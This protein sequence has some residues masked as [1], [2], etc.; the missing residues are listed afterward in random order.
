MFS[1]INMQIACIII[2][3]SVQPREC[4]NNFIMNNPKINAWQ[5]M[6]SPD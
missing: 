4:Y 6:K 2:G 3:S 1:G 5:T